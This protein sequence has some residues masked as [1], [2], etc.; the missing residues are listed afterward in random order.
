MPDASRYRRLACGILEPG[1]PCDDQT[2]SHFDIF[3]CMVTCNI[4]HTPLP[5]HAAQAWT[6]LSAARQA[7]AAKRPLALGLR[8]IKGTK[9]CECCGLCLVCRFNTAAE[10]PAGSAMPETGT[11]QTA[12][13]A[14]IRIS[15]PHTL[16]G[17]TAGARNPATC[18]SRVGTRGLACACSDI[19]GPGGRWLPLAQLPRR[20]RGAAE[21]KGAN[22][23]LLHHWHEMSCYKSPFT[24]LILPALD[25]ACWCAMA[26][27]AMTAATA[28]TLAADTWAYAGSHSRPRP[29]YAR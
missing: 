12:R 18:T 2:C 24:M 7:A 21:G 11:Q 22:P 1:A 6:G 17:T 26:A 25:K 27:L 14:G 19:K 15:S 16:E 3:V 4:S 9:S 20:E 8:L 28:D 5:L 13:W 23:S 10:R 29:I